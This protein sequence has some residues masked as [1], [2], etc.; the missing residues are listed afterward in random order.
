MS[1]FAQFT[2][3]GNVVMCRMTATSAQPLTTEGM[4]AFLGDLKART[5]AQSASF[6][7]VLDAR[8]IEKLPLGGGMT[9]AKRISAFMTENEQQMRL[10]DATAVVVSST[11]VSGV[12]NT[13]FGIRRPAKPVKT[14][15]D[16]AAAKTFLAK[17]GI[18]F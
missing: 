8:G 3:V 14:V 12:L 11:L 6:G 2:Q 4:D 5:T 9:L 15:D 13:A 18:V 17:H 10:C 16:I 1:S 7:L